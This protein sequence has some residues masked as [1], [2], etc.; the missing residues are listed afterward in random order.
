[1]PA[2][3]ICHLLNAET[4]RLYK[5]TTRKIIKNAIAKA[6]LPFRGLNPR[7]GLITEDPATLL[8]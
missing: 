6:T 7:T 2:L 4:I 8:P 1:M 3:Q 5:P